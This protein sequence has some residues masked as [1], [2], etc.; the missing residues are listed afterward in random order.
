MPERIAV[1]IV[2][3]AADRQDVVRLEVDNGTTV[4]AAV[5]L[6]AVRALRPDWPWD[7]CSYAVFGR[8]VEPTRVLRPGDRIEVLRPLLHDPKLTRRERAARRGSARRR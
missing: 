7:R 3:A 1:E 4:A 6:G 5:D 8:G 2:V